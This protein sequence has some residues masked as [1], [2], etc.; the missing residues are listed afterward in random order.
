MRVASRRFSCLL[1]P[2]VPRLSHYR[3]NYVSYN[4]IL[5][6]YARVSNTSEAC[7]GENE[8]KIIAVQTRMK[9][10][11]NGG[12]SDPIGVASNKRLKDSRYPTLIDGE[13]FA[14]L[15]TS[16][17]VLLK[18]EIFPDPLSLFPSIPVHVL[19]LHGNLFP[20]EV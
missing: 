13:R 12:V 7:F 1:S 15:S 14:I 8:R 4:G 6:F 11:N 2:S 10:R 16:K 5:T 20:T 3:R 9:I 17:L 18:I 19:E